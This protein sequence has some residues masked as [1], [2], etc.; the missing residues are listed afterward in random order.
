MDDVD[1]AWE[2]TEAHLQQ[3]LALRLRSGTGQASR[4]TCLDCEE[5][6]PPERRTAAVGCVRCLD[7][8]TVIEK[9]RKP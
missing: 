5:E 9:R 6:I 4:F 8:Q 1:L 2:C 7:C 3:A